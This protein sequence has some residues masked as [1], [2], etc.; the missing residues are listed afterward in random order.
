MSVTLP[1]HERL[2]AVLHYLLDEG[3][4]KKTDLEA[5]LHILIL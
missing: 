2:S 5:V 1:T 4:E 3:I